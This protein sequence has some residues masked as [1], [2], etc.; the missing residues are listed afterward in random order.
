MDMLREKGVVVC[1]RAAPETI[2]R[3]TERSENRPLLK[4]G[5]PLQ[6]IRDLLNDRIPFY[7]KAD[8]IIDTDNKTPLQIAEEIVAR[9]KMT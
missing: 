4:G 1:L 8:I 7:E 2:L 9:V 5:D 6:K 3:R